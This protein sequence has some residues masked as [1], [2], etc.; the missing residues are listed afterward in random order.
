MNYVFFKYNNKTFKLYL[1]IKHNNNI[2]IPSITLHT[3]NT[4]YQK[5]F[6]IDFKFQFNY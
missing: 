6:N 3:L 1:I 5:C 4:C 2:N